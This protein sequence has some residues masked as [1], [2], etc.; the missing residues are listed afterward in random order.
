MFYRLVG[1]DSV[2]VNSIIQ[3]LV[4]YMIEYE[5]H[6]VLNCIDLMRYER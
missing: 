2:N 5:V 6:F 1:S 3:I 4:S